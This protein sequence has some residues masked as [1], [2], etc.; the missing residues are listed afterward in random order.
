MPLMSTMRPEMSQLSGWLKACAPCRG[1]QAGH[2]VQGGLRAGRRL[3]RAA[4]DTVCTQR[5][6][7]IAATADIAGAKRG[8]RRTKNMLP[9]LVTREVSQLRGWLKAFAPCRG[10]QAGH[11]VRGG[12]R[13]AGEAAGGER[14][15]RGRGR[16]CC[17]E[18]TQRT[19]NIWCMSVTLDVSQSEM[20][21]S[22]FSKPLKSSLMSVMAETSQAAILPYRA[23]AAVGSV[24]YASIAV[25]RES[26]VVKVV[27]SMPASRR[28]FVIE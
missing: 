10:S 24:L 1:S 4:G 13:A 15:W 2:T 17:G 19:R 11:T 6:G 9:I 5:A 27:V 16:L 20:Y 18:H 3:R 12:L 8:E 23:M 14:P 21:A 25:F 26:F 7:E 28:A 22:K